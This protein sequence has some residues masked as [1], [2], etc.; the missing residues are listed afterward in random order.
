MDG[1]QESTT[2][3]RVIEIREDGDEEEPQIFQIEKSPTRENI[4]I[5]TEHHVRHCHTV[6]RAAKKIVFLSF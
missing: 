3:I 2:F 4:Y 1:L 5:T 6:D